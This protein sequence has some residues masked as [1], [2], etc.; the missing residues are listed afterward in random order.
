[1]ALGLSDSYMGVVAE[2]IVGISNHATNEDFASSFYY[3]MGGGGSVFVKPSNRRVPT[4]DTRVNATLA[5]CLAGPQ[6]IFDWLNSNVCSSVGVHSM[7][8]TFFFLFEKSGLASSLPSA[9]N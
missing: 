7:R 2:E 6:C 9:W 5:R 1:M 4:W 3:S 8:T